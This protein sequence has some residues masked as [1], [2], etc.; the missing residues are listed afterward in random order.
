MMI[1]AHISGATTGAVKTLLA[2]LYARIP[3]KLWAICTV[4]GED[5]RVIHLHDTGSGISQRQLLAWQAD[6][7]FEIDRVNNRQV[8]P[9]A[10]GE[11]PESGAPV[12]EVPRRRPAVIDETRTDVPVKAYIGVPLYD[13]TR[14]L[15]TLCGADPEPDVAG[16]RHSDGLV[17][18]TAN[19]I[20]RLL[21]MEA[22]V[23]TQRMMAGDRSDAT[24]RDALS[25][26]LNRRGWDSVIRQ[27]RGQ[28]GTHV[29]A[30][31]VVELWGL[32]KT[33][34]HTGVDA[35][36]R[37]VKS[38]ADSLTNTMR[39]HDVVA[40]LGLGSFGVLLHC[41]SAA[42]VPLIVARVE[43]GLVRDG[44]T[45]VIGHA[46][47]PPASSLDAAFITAH[48]IMV[49]NKQRAVALPAVA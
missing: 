46:S 41:D 5:W 17:R 45:A 27:T 1:E 40:R 44:V 18:Q 43:Q 49:A 13:G 12:Y 31:I 38:T 14:L 6:F 39:E 24:R 3:L 9:K 16:V 32:Q 10:I 21:T 42:M 48:R 35:A 26:L 34:E 30:V 20:S 22:H 19:L 23:N 4:D 15:G 8:M 37:L 25:G 2:S 7:G 28:F 29:H 47:S 11:L 33:A 36:D